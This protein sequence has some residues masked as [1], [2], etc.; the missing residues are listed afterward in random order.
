VSEKLL[1]LRKISKS[2]LGVNALKEVDFHVSRGEVVSL[3]G[4]NGAGKST[5]SHIISGIYKPDTGKIFIDGKEVEISDVNIADDFGIGMVH[6]EPTLV[7]NMTVV[8]NTFLNREIIKKTGVLDERKMEDECTRILNMLGYK[9]N[10][11]K[12]ISALSIVEK[13]IVEITKA[14]LLSPR[15][16][17][18]DE[19]TAPLN[20][21]E[22]EHLFQIIAELKKHDLAIIFIGHRIQEVRR[23]SDRVSILRDGQIVAELTQGEISSEKEIIKPMLGESGEFT[24]T[25]KNEEQREWK[26]RGEKPLL[27]LKSLTKLK[28]FKD[29]NLSLY[30]G[31]IIGLAGLKGAGIT[32]LFKFIYGRG[33]LD[34]GTV[35]VKGKN[36][37]ITSPSAAI[38]KCGIGFVTNDRQSEGLALIRN[39]EENTSVTVL[40]KT[41]LLRRKEITK[42]VALYVRELDIKTPNLRQ[43]VQFLSGG[44]QQKIVIAKWLLRNL[45][46]LLIDEPTRGVDIQAKNEIYRLIIEQKQKQKGII[47]TSPE[48][49]ELV[50]LCDR[51]F[52]VVFGKIICE[53]KR[54]EAGFN[55]ENILSLMHKRA[56]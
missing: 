6:Q 9:I 49:Y 13:T 50:N 12:R 47:V 3:V 56:E 18:L 46:I 29:F 53:I 28:Y 55:E 42:D 36:E 27:E 10:V 30:A 2:F 25:T 26:S 52:V 34:S 32:E 31:E 17:I 39:V 1:E 15:I 20:G 48:I 21:S 14:M 54:G 16:L 11:Y 45:Q 35:V 38:K 22:V 5:L 7:P 40:D 44:N 24:D 4:T 33:K 23:I 43:E 8:A 19:V 51:I 41:W 37:L